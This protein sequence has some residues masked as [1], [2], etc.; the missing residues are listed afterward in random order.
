MKIKTPSADKFR[1][2]FE[3]SSDAHF[4]MTKDG[5]TDC[6]QATIRLLKYSCKEEILSIHPAK[7]SPL[8]QP[9]G[10]LSLEKSVEMDALAVKN[11]FHRFEWYHQKKDGEVFPVEVTL[12]AFELNGA[13]AFI[14]VWHDL[15]L[16]KKKEDHLTQA[17][18][19]MKRDLEAAAQ[20]Q[21]SLLPVSSPLVKGFRASWIFRPCDELGGD[22]LN[23]FPLDQTHVGLYVLDVTGHGVA[24]SLLSVA[25]S[26]F[27]SPYSEASF[28]RNTHHI[29]KLSIAE[30][31]EVAE[32]LNRH[33]CSNPDLM[34]LFT[35]F[36]G[37]LDVESGEFCY[38]SAGHPP[39]VIISS[40]GRSRMAEGSGLPIGVMQ[41]FE[42]T[43]LCLKL[44]PTERLYL[45]S[46]GLTEARNKE[47]ELFGQKRLVSALA[48]AQKLPL[49]QS[50][51]KIVNEITSWCSPRHPDDDVTLLACQL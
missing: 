30:P 32:K 5:I 42:Y 18:E 20:I 17:N 9:D 27:L 35:L 34:Q 50:T 21:K 25:A 8:Y 43:Q 16:L 13:P 23:V 36:Y 49:A 7:L 19:K 22:I 38:V 33:F 45:Y 41:D 26:H 4:I 40:D 10:R 47:N 2:L 39:P 24:A 11:G 6:N 15:T 51:E 48:S 44:K 12:N 14:A 28:V 46:D 3:H 1:L 31:V 29:N 37:V